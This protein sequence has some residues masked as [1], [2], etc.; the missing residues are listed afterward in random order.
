[1][2]HINNLHDS[3]KWWFFSTSMKHPSEFSS[4][5]EGT[6]PGPELMPPRSGKRMKMLWNMATCGFY[7]PKLGFH[8]KLMIS[9]Y[10]RSPGTRK[11]SGLT[12]NR[13]MSLDEHGDISNKIEGFHSS[14]VD[15]LTIF[16]AFIRET[17]DLRFFPRFFFLDLWIQTQAVLRIASVLGDYIHRWCFKHVETPT[18]EASEIYWPCLV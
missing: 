6:I 7:S 15:S 5:D 8:S 4:F 17:E 9:C 11:N 2:K 12:A 18:F 16:K 13:G 1:M 10:I 14:T 3:F